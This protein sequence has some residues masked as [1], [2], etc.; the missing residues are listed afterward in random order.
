MSSI[1]HNSNIAPIPSIAPIDPIWFSEHVLAWLRDFGSCLIITGLLKNPHLQ[2]WYSIFQG[3]S[4]WYKPHTV[5]KKSIREHW[6][7]ISHESKGCFGGYLA[8]QI[9]AHW[10]Q[11]LKVSYI[12]IAKQA[13]GNLNKTVITSHAAR[14]IPQMHRS[15][16]L[17]HNLPVLDL[18]QSLHEALSIQLLVTNC[19]NMFK[20]V[21]ACARG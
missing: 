21:G 16:Q 7:S 8:L 1:V 2:H 11:I 18:Y 4:A 5:K 10:S 15:P 13:K 17:E 19:I 3:M 14:I 20:V 12:K 6:N 9:L